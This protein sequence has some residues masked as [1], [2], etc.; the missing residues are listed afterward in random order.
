MTDDELIAEMDQR[1]AHEPEEIRAAWLVVRKHLRAAKRGDK[2]SRPLGLAAIT[3]AMREH[4]ER[5]AATVEETA[6]RFSDGDGD[7]ERR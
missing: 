5:T 6:R 2:A 3:T 7:G 4:A 1:I